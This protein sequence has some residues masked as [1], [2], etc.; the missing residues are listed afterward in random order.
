[1][2][3]GFR[4]NRVIN[5]PNATFNLQPSTFN[6]QPST[7]NLQ[8]ATFNLQPSTCNLFLSTPGKGREMLS[9]RKG[10]VIFSQGDASDAVFVVQTGRVRLSAKARRGKETTLDILGASDLVGKDSIVGEST[11]TTSANALTDC[12]LLRID[13]K[14]MMLA[15]SEEVGLAILV[16]TYV[17]KRN[18]RYQKD[19]VD[20]RCNRSE[21][22]LARAL[23]G[24]ARLEALEPRETAIPKI[25]QAMLAEI[26]GTTRSRVSLFM[27]GFR[28]A[29]FIEYSLKGKEVRVRPSLLDFYAD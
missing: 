1:M 21:K 3:S 2:D 9:Y 18:L 29:G 16:C 14:V 27:N 11:R 24:L 13:S 6:L 26:V 23:L 10:Q 4:R 5:G 19:L 8:P 17:I 7:C 22:R 15:L 12:Q 20:Q 25:N 28:D